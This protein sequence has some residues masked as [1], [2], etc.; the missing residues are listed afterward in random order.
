MSPVMLLRIVLVTSSHP[1][2][3]AMGWV[4]VADI[5]SLRECTNCQ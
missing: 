3:D 5:L 4:F 2:Y 1:D